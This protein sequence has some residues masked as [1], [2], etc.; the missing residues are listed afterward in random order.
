MSYSNRYS[1]EITITPPLTAAEIR[2]TP[3]W[4]EQTWHTHLRVQTTTEQTPDGEI[5]RYTA[6]AILGPDEPCSG[7]DVKDQIQALVE[8]FGGGHTFA[9][10]MQVDWDPGFGEL[11]TRYV[12]RDGRVTEVRP[13]LLWPGVAIR[14]AHGEGI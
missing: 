14:S 9:G 3:D 2:Q 10:H 6:D 11:P 12:V 1:G 8:Q 5:T 7:Y 4:A 13:Q